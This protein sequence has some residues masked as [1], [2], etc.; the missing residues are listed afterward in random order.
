MINLLIPSPIGP[1]LTGATAALLGVGWAVFANGLLCCVGIGLAYIYLLR[2]RQNGTNF[3]YA[4]P[5]AAEES[6]HEKAEIN[7]DETG[8]R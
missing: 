4:A 1:M 8:S 6:P 3:E 7:A 2:H 5:V